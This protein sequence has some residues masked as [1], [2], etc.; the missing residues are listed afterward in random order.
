VPQVTPVA[1]TD[2]GTNSAA[3]SSTDI[4]PNRS[5]HTSAYHTDAGPYYTDEGAHFGADAP[6]TSAH[7]LAYY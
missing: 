3:H 5:A 7:S 6:H 1:S 4:P 2:G